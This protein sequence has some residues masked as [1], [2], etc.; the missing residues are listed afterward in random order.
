MLL[1]GTYLPKGRTLT[2]SLITR[3]AR[4]SR[5]RVAPRA[6]RSLFMRWVGW[7]CAQVDAHAKGFSPSRS[8]GNDLFGGRS[9]AGALA[10]IR[11][12]TL[13]ICPK[14]GLRRFLYGERDARAPRDALPLAVFFASGGLFGGGSSAGVLAFIRCFT[15]RIC[16]NDGLRRFLYGERDA[17]A[18]G[19][20]R[21]KLLCW[22]EAYLPGG[23]ALARSLF[24]RRARRSRARVAPGHRA[25]FQLSIINSQPPTI[26][27]PLS[28][29]HLPRFTLLYCNSQ[30]W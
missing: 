24:I 27:Y 8:A 13:L 5:A 28:I 30:I 2:G 18:P 29:I 14:D 3:R 23:R 20:P 25:C 7:A 15:L 17:R 16:P 19:L 22:R 1:G 12:F 10:F 11:C 9:S 6:P 26:N 4:R 21:L